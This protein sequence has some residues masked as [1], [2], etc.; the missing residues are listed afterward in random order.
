MASKL[1]LKAREGSTF[2]IVAEFFER[3]TEDQEGTPIIP[4]E[5]L[6][7]SL[8]DEDG[9]PVNDRTKEPLESAA[10]VV[11]VLSGGDL[12][13]V[14][15]YPVLRYV[16]IE[17]TYNSLLGTNLALIDEVSFQIENLSG[18]SSV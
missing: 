7:W 15:D 1:S 2:G 16:T 11:I 4:N 8:T 3:T 5:G 18:V 10:T 6:T 12:A 9:N 14:N 17:G 13:L